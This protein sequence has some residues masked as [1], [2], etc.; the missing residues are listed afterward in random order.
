MGKTGQF[1]RLDAVVDTAIG[2]TIV[3]AN[4]LIKLKGELVYSRQAGLLDR[5]A[6]RSMTSRTLFRLASV[7][8]PMVSVAALAMA[9]AGKAGRKAVLLLV[10]RQDQQ[11]FVTVPFSVG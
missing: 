4:I 8:K 7:S 3:G 10:L 2:R 1:S 5:E 6:D 9:E 11:S